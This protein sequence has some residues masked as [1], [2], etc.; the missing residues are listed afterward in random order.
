MQQLFGLEAVD[1]IAVN[2]ESFNNSAVIPFGLETAHIKRSMEDFIDFLKFMNTQLRTKEIP[3]LETFLMPAGFSS[4][5]GEFMNIRIPRYCT[6]LVKNKSQWPSRPDPGW[7]V[8]GK[9]GSSRIRR[10]RGQTLSQPC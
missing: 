1:P 9:R 10:H 4:L 5:V 3:R 8:S 6:A 7:A 2:P